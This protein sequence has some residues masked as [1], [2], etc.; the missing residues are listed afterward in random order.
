MDDANSDDSEAVIL[1]HLSHLP[2]RIVPVHFTGMGPTWTQLVHAGLLHY[3]QATHGIIA[4]ADFAPMSP[5]L[6]GYELDVRCSKH[7]YT[8]WT[9]DHLTSRRMDWIYRNLHGVRVERRTHQIL[10]A[11]ELPDQEVFQTLVSLD[12]DERTGGFQDRSGAKD[13]RYIHWLELDLLDYPNDPRTLYYLA[14]AHL[15]LYQSAAPDAAS[16]LQQAIAYFERRAAVE[17]GN[18]EERWFAMLKLGE[19]QERFV[20]D[21]AAAERWYLQ[22]VELDGERVDPY[23]YLGQHFRLSGV[24]DRAY[25]WLSKAV[26]LERPD[27]ALFQ[28]ELLY[29]CLRFI[30]FGEAV[31]RWKDASHAQ[32]QEATTILAQA[33]CEVEADKMTSLRQLREAVQVKAARM[34]KKTKAVSDA[35]VAA[36][37]GVLSFMRANKAAVEGVGREEVEA[38]RA[39]V[40]E[41]KEL[42]GELRSGWSTCR[43]F[44]QATAG[45]VKWWHRHVDALPPGASTLKW[46][47]VS[48]EIV[49]LCR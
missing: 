1:R 41:W 44:R 43:R 38:M 29:H 24:Y 8:V 42:D 25:H 4:D 5:V 49:E 37:K 30:E 19:V 46:K 39:Y 6:D 10:T 16:H 13:A 40:K 17:A 21:W 12:V 18:L 31:S 14:Y 23:F 9:E 3:P 11:P 26:R 7:L 27:R 2:G 47:E 34:G 36:V 20:K 35:K 15:N 33:R 22:A 32:L 28:W 48:E 45:Y